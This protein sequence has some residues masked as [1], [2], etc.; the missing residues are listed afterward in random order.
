MYV[1]HCKLR[2][3]V[4]AMLNLEVIERT[5]DNSG[6]IDYVS[7]ARRENFSMHVNSSKLSQES[8][9]GL[10]FRRSPFRCTYSRP[11]WRWR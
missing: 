5:I 1:A 11:L 3:K 2:S 4:V 6:S 8:D 10:S 9:C 7:D